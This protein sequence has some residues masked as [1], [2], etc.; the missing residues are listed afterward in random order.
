MKTIKPIAYILIGVVLGMGV[1]S[2]IH[3]LQSVDRTSQNIEKESLA[4][5][6]SISTLL[7]E[8][9]Y[10]KDKISASGM[11]EGS[12]QW[13]VNALKD[14]YTEYF[15]AEKNTSFTSALKG[16]ESFE[17][18]GAALQKKDEGAIIQEVYKW[19]PAAIAGLRPLDM[20]VEVSGA[21]TAG[22][23]LQEIVSKIRG[24]KDTTVKLTIFRGSEKELS[25][26]IFT[27]EVTRKKVD[28]PSVSSELIPL[29]WTQ[30]NLW[31]ISISIVGEETE[32]LLEKEIAS[33]SWKNIAGVV[34]DLRGN[35]GW[36]LPKS[37]EIA[38]H[39]IPKG[40]KVV[41]AKYSLF[42]SET[43]ISKWYGEFETVPL[44]VLVDGLTA[45]AG[46]II[47]GALQQDRGATLVGTKTFGKWSIQTVGDVGS[48][49]SLKYTIGK[50]Y[51]PDDTNIDHEGIKPDIE[52]LFDKDAY[53]KNARDVQE[54]KAIEIL[55]ANVSKYLIK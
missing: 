12:I 37:V 32:A 36:F 9:Y 26:K 13:F 16:E 33:L 54:E 28:I 44:V 40:K 46:E 45:S 25:K 17:W 19:T 53:Q 42:P 48:G 4:T 6:H 35:G 14:P 8:W 15:P 5:M 31:L 24:P 10:D 52:V 27:V 20:I 38:S 1:M 21:K 23:D 29:T 49:T 47:A 50:R 18:I 43:Y 39:F 41:T 22:M 30:K 34:L 11:R 51:L 55:K 7:R 2:W 3:P